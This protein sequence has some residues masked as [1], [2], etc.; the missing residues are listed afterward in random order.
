MISHLAA[1]YGSPVERP[2]AKNLILLCPLA[3]SHRVGKGS[4]SLSVEVNPG[5]PSRAHCWNC[6]IGG[7]LTYVFTVAHGTLGSLD[8][9]LAFVVD[10]DKGDLESA[11]N[12]CRCLRVEVPKAADDGT[13]AGIDR[14][15]AKC[16]RFVPRYLIDERGLLATD[17]RR[18]QLGYDQERN[19][20]VFPVRNENNQ[21]VGAVLRA[22]AKDDKPKYLNTPGFKTTNCFYG[23]QHVD[24]TLERGYLVEGPVSEIYADR[25]LPNSLGLFGAKTGIS[26]VRLEKLRRWFRRI[27]LIL[28]G[29]EAGDAAVYGFTDE[30]GKHHLG[31][32]EI[33]KPYFPVDVVQLPYKEDPASITPDILLRA[34]HSSR[35][36]FT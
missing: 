14:Y 6:G 13:T 28:D 1:L 18:W 5:A 3:S 33:L 7:S 15:I 35:Y 29:D 25:V 31:L 10:N 21:L 27:T 2:H 9:A 19:R 34:V 32:Q 22:I 36:L 11:L 30:G 12:H 17:I 20:A 24:P 26:P 4:A 8:A 23:E 16:S